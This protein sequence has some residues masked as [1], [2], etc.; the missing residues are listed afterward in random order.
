MKM[1]LTALAALP[2]CSC[3]GVTP[4]EGLKL[5]V[6]LYCGALSEASRQVVRDQVTGGTAVLA[7]APE[8]A[9]P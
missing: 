6:E 2:L 4:Q 7:C 9:R 8:T 5:G 1:I 3:A